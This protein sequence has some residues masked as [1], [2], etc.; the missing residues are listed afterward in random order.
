ML[1]FTRSDRRRRRPDV[2]PLLQVPAFRHC[3]PRQLAE[4]APHTD[5]LRLSPGRTLVRAGDRGRE[6][7]V[8]VAGEA[9]VIRGGRQVAVLTPGAQ[10]GGRETLRHERHDATVVATSDLEVVVVNGPAVRWAHQEC[11]S[12]LAPQASRPGWSP[13]RPPTIQHHARVAS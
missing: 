10:I 11:A 3:T 4:M 6:L 9:A 2:G 12:G 1:S 8:V 7:V 5:R 13:A